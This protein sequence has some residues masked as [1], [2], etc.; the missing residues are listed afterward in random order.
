M[1]GLTDEK[2]GN[3]LYTVVSEYWYLHFLAVLTKFYTFYFNIF[4]SKKRKSADEK[5]LS[6]LIFT[7]YLS[8]SI[9]CILYIHTNM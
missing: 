2:K 8:V 9:P 7:Y 3:P 5:K 1:K 4:C 6:S